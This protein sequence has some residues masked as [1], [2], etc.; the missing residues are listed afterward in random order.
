MKENGFGQR[1]LLTMVEDIFSS[2]ISV[3][4]AKYHQ[5]R[6]AMTAHLICMKAAGLR[7]VDYEM[8]MAVSGFGLSFVYE[9]SEK[10]WVSFVPPPGC[11]KRLAEATGFG[12]E[13]LKLETPETAWAVL[14][15]TLSSGKPVRAPYLEELIFAG[16]EEAEKAEDRKVFVLCEPFMNPGKWWNWQEFCDWFEKHSFGFIGRHTDLVECKGQMG[17]AQ[18]IMRIIVQWANNHPMA[19]DRA[20]DGVK[21]GIEG[22]LE[23]AKDVADTSLTENY[24]DRGWNG[25]YSIYPQWTARICTAS[26]LRQVAKECGSRVR[27]QLL[28]IA[29]LY[30][31]AYSAWRVFEVYLGKDVPGGAWD[32]PARRVAGAEAILKAIEMEK[33]AIEEIAELLSDNEG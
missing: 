3:T 28:S 1:V 29:N 20:Y 18:E 10:F 21:F 27:E 13:W 30:E 15:E 22:L 7:S 19:E 31:R 32:D 6:S 24:F 17:I 12:W 25:C 8:L 26:Y 23:Y 14:K 33:K 2:V 5:P 11:Y 4:K 16:F 9:H